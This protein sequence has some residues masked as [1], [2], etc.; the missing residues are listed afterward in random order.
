[1]EYRADDKHVQEI[2]GYFGLESG[3]KGL[4][5]AMVKEPVEEGDAD[6]DLQ[7][8]QVREYRALAARANYLSL[9]RPDIQCAA[10]EICRD[11]AK[12]TTRSRA[13]VKR[14]ARYLLEYPQA[15]IRFN[16]EIDEWNRDAINVYSDSDW[17][18]C[19]KTRRSTTGGV[20]VVDGGVTK[21]WSSMQATVA[22]SSGEAEYYAMVRAAAEALG[23]QSI[24]RDL[25]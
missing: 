6:E 9:D 22:Q 25:G 19:A 17:A 10:K 21:T 5:A 8:P 15:T 2:T 24:M 18:G 23:M 7:A 12:P 16:A 20:M 13:K 14:L 4:S 11:M 3:S 1:M